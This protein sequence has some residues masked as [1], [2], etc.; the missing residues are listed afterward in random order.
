MFF[1]PYFNI[2]IAIIKTLQNAHQ[3]AKIRSGTEQ[4]YHICF[5]DVFTSSFAIGGGR[6]GEVWYCI[7]S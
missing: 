3:H 2:I 5:L 4:V 6:A 1:F 7:K